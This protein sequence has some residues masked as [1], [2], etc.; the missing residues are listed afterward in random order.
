[1]RFSIVAIATAAVTAAGTSAI[2]VA[3]KFNVFVTEN[4]RSDNSG[5][6]PGYE[7]IPK[8]ATNKYSQNAPSAI[9]EYAT[10]SFEPTY[11]P[12]ED[13]K[14]SSIHARSIT[15]TS[16]TA[17]SSTPVADEPSD[18]SYEAFVQWMNARLAQGASAQA[19]H[20]HVAH[21]VA[22]SSSANV[23]PSI[24]GPVDDTYEAFVTWMESRYPKG[25]SEQVKQKINAQDVE[26]QHATTTTSTTTPTPAATTGPADESY[27]EFARWMNSRFPQGIS[28]E[29]EHKNFARS[30]EE[31]DEY[32][33]HEL[34]QRSVDTP[35]ASQEHGYEEPDWNFAFNEELKH[36]LRAR[37]AEDENHASPSEYGSE[38]QQEPSPDGHAASESEYPYLE[39]T[40]E[41]FLARQGY[42]LEQYV[43]ESKA[44]ESHKKEPEPQAAVD[45]KPSVSEV[46][47]S[48]AAAPT[49]KP[50]SAVTSSVTNSTSASQWSSQMSETATVSSSSATNVQARS[51][52]SHRRFRHH[53]AH[54]SNSVTASASSATS[55]TTTSRKGFFNLPW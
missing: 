38:Y 25:F 7:A 54:A 20:S 49:P 8:A 39:E 9:P 27:E 21:S 36:H 31:H 48:P 43:Q 23:E 46:A 17:V 4:I 29:N 47:A 51:V 11:M 10:G 55:S 44:T 24:D 33:Y 42:S 35:E 41:E 40:F 50:T 45:S 53:S 13:L 16:A 6:V 3:G 30:L 32:E 37:S 52:S 22:P 19:E 1:M 26:T 28:E 2:D 15:S 14:P 12:E 34:D 18:D 5:E